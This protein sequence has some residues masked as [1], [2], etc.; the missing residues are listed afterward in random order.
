MGNSTVTPAVSQ[1][2]HVPFPML[3]P[4]ESGPMFDSEMP[5]VSSYS[6]PAADVPTNPSATGTTMITTSHTSV[7]MVQPDGSSNV[8]KSTVHR[9]T[10]NNVES[11]TVTN[12][13]TFPMPL[14]SATHRTSVYVLD[15]GTSR[16]SGETSPPNFPMSSDTRTSLKNDNISPTKPS[17]PRTSTVRRPSIFRLTS[18]ASRISMNMNSASPR[19]LPERFTPPL[20]TNT[21]PFTTSMKPPTPSVRRTSVFVLDANASH[22]PTE[23]LSNPINSVVKFDTS[24]SSETTN[25]PT[26]NTNNDK[27]F[28]KSSMPPTS[29]NFSTSVVQ[30]VTTTTKTSTQSTNLMTSAPVTAPT[31]STPVIPVNS[32][33]PSV[34]NIFLKSTNSSPTF[35]P[36]TSAVSPTYDAPRT[37]IL[38]SPPTKTIAPVVSTVSY[39]RPSLSKPLLHPSTT[40]TTTTSTTTNNEHSV[41]LT[42]PVAKAPVS[43]C[44]PPFNLQ[45]KLHQTIPFLLQVNVFKPPIS[46]NTISTSTQTREPTD[47]TS[48]FTNQQNNKLNQKEKEEPIHSMKRT[49]SFATS[50]IPRTD[51]NEKSTQ[52]IPTIKETHNF[53]T[54]PIPPTDVNENPKEKSV[55]LSIVAVPSFALRST[56][57]SNFPPDDEAL[58]ERAES[59]HKDISIFKYH[60]TQKEIKPNIGDHT[61]ATMFKM[62]TH[63]KQTPFPTP[64][65]LF[66]NKNFNDGAPEID[67]DSTI[68][69]SFSSLGL[70]NDLDVKTSAHSTLETRLNDKLQ[71]KN[72]QQRLSP[73]GNFTHNDPWPII[74]STA[75]NEPIFFSSQETPAQNNHPPLSSILKKPAFQPMRKS[76]AT[77]TNIEIFENLRKTKPDTISSITKATQISS[78]KETIPIRKQYPLFEYN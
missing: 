72:I 22:V 27:F 54:S 3:Y 65:L 51:T 11:S 59:I 41:K 15:A 9:S 68:T 10:M 64:S 74:S 44:L 28:K 67:N 13:E 57:V 4:H 8:T 60:V 46:M 63:Q 19:A 21:E 29:S 71:Q 49:H 55:V 56:A 52:S 39:S 70:D 47:L 2:P 76:S 7:S 25:I 48:L 6:F 53:A 17:T 5:H 26:N 1:P 30:V 77:Q 42:T 43:R 20:A 32:P 69:P 31:V 34:D 35:S 61:K 78:C 36:D 37:P 33:I 40:T 73:N 38:S 66:L 16:T 45:V 18:E 58:L 24:T 62:N 12:L 23:P 50:P 14:N 75:V